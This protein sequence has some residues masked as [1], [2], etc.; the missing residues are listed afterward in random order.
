TLIVPTSPVLYAV[1]AMLCISALA[2]LRAALA[3][4]RD[5]TSF[6]SSLLLLARLIRIALYDST[7]SSSSS[8]AFW[9]FLVTSLDGAAYAAVAPVPEIASAIM[10]TASVRNLVRTWDNA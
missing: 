6:A 3:G 1:A 4:P 9:I 10:T 7:T 2:T 8:D 5:L